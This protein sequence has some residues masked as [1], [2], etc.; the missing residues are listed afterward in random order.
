ME[1]ITF[2]C[3]LCGIRYNCATLNNDT[4]K[5]ILNENF[6]ILIETPKFYKCK[7]CKLDFKILKQSLDLIK[8]KYTITEY[9]EYSVIHNNEYGL[10]YGKFCISFD[11][12][13]QVFIYQERN[14]HREYDLFE[15]EFFETIKKNSIITFPNCSEKK[16]HIVNLFAQKLSEHGFKLREL[17]NALGYYNGFYYIVDQPVLTKPA[18]YKEQCN[19]IE[20]NN[21]F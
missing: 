2:Y 8:T 20:N 16:Y 9:L 11:E 18:L 14:E 21:T 15:E 7:S 12:T 1:T 3:T 5:I 17:K 6:I 10:K 19:K 4:I 13:L